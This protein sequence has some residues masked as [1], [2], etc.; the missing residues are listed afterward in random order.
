[1]KT[2]SAISIASNHIGMSLKDLYILY[3]YKVQGEL[4]VKIEV[5]VIG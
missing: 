3:L 4:E 1:L 5:D 2:F